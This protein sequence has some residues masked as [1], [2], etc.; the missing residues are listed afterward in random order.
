MWKKRISELEKA[1]KQ[2]E[3]TVKSN[4]IHEKELKTQIYDSI[5]YSE[6]LFKEKSE[7]EWNLAGA[8][9]KVF[10]IKIIIKLFFCFFFVFYK[11][12]Y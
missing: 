9:H 11:E 3:E 1:I 7:L 6:A 10:F 12:N 4:D 5:S 8:Q 2:L